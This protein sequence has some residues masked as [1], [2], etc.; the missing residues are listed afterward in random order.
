MMPMSLKTLSRSLAVVLVS[1]VLF[2]QTGAQQT[3]TYPMVKRG[4]LT[5]ATSRAKPDNSDLLVVKDT[6]GNPLYELAIR[7]TSRDSRTTDAV[8]L[9]LFDDKRAAEDLATGGY[10]LLSEGSEARSVFAAAL[11]CGTTETSSDATLR[12]PRREFEVRGMRLVAVLD[13]LRCER[14]AVPPGEM[15]DGIKRARITVT[16]EPSMNTQEARR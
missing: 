12:Q 4:R 2:D 11:M 10:N 16:V 6:Q 8:Y 14:R 9:Y 3:E 5:V 7:A 1:L 15:Y 13:N